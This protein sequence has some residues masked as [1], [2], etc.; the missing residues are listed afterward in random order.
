MG[1]AGPLSP[2]AEGDALLSCM[3]WTTG[4][5]LFAQIVDIEAA[6]IC[7]TS[8]P[9][10]ITSIEEK[11]DKNSRSNL[12]LMQLEAGKT[13]ELHKGGTIRRIYFLKNVKK[14][15]LS[16]HG[17]ADGADPLMWVLVYWHDFLQKD[18]Q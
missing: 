2:S 6:G 12:L 9:R 13:V 1:R 15:T 14:A 17:Q 3:G 4:G 5:N 7:R 10:S 8:C 16:V 11:F 18:F